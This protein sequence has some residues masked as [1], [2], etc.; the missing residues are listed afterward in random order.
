MMRRFLAY[1]S[2]VLDIA[3]IYRLLGEVVAGAAGHGPVHLLLSSVGVIGFAW[4]PKQCVWVWPGHPHLC[5]LA[6]P[7]QFFKSAVLG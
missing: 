6:S 3:R 7:L 4:D 2:G 1:N 5:Q